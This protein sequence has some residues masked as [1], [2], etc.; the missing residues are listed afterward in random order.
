MTVTHDPGDDLRPLLATAV[1]DGPASTDLLAGVRRAQRGRR[2]L[3]RVGSL[4]T[5]GA[6]ATAALAVWT[7]G[8]APSAQAQLV[9]AVEQSSEQ[10]FHVHGVSKAAGREFD[11]VFDPATKTGRITAPGGVQQLFVAGTIYTEHA[12]PDAKPLPAGKRWVSA[13]MMT[14]AE[15]AQLGTTVEVLKRSTLDPQLVLRQLRSATNVQETG[16]ASGAGWTGNRYSFTIADTKDAKGGR[17]SITGTVAVDSEELVRV[18]DLNVRSDGPAGQGGDVNNVV[19]E[20][21]DYGTT[22][23]VTAPPAEQVISTDQLED[24]KPSTSDHPRPTGRP[25]DT[26]KSKSPPSGTNPP[27]PVA[28]EAPDPSDS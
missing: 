25:D 2:V 11:G 6:L 15:W 16:P 13:P 19:L 12:G 5:A 18:L 1:S 26:D 7:V 27:K 20:F 17:L 23:D 4:A 14:D 24:V 22:V 28:S 9:A 21:S 3:V 8:N 10:G